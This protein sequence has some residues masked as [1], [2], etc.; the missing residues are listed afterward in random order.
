MIDWDEVI[1]IGGG[2][3][4]AVVVVAFI[5]LL[6]YVIYDA[7]TAETFSLRKDQ[8]T[9]TRSHT[10][11]TSTMTT[12]DGGKTWVPMVQSNTVCDQWERHA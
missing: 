8:W 1:I 4:I 11:V 10:E 12:Y 7:I 9:C 2:V 3:V 6:G 5:G